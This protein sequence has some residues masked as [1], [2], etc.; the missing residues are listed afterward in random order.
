MNSKIWVM[1]SDG[2][3]CKVGKVMAIRSFWDQGPT[4]YESQLFSIIGGYPLD[5][6]FYWYRN[7]NGAIFIP[8]IQLSDGDYIEFPATS[9]GL[10]VPDT[11]PLS[12][13]DLY[14]GIQVDRNSVLSSQSAKLTSMLLDGKKCVMLTN[15][16][17]G[18]GINN[19]VRGGAYQTFTFM[20][21]Y[22]SGWVRLFALRAGSCSTAWGGWSI[23]G[24]I[25]A[26]GKLW[27]GMK[28]GSPDFDLWISTT[29]GSIPKD[30]WTHITFSMDDDFKGITLL[31]DGI[32]I[33]RKRVESMN[34][35]DYKNMM[36]NQVTIGHYAW[37]CNGPSAPPVLP[38]E[39][40]PL[41]TT[42]D[43][44]KYLGCWNEA[45]GRALP[46]LL[47]KVS[48]IVECGDLAKKASL[49]RFGLQ[50]E[51]ECWGGNNLDWNRG[52]RVNDCPPLGRANSNQVYE[53]SRTPPL[54]DCP[55]SIDGS[56]NICL[57]WVHWFDY[58]LDPNAALSDKGLGF[59]DTKVY[60]EDHTTGWQNIFLKKKGKL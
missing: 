36:Y 30:K 39:P 4:A 29:P 8:K 46:N 41:A 32:M 20:T 13:W 54:S 28:R 17:A 45:N 2:V 49:A 31:L 42:M 51:G 26:E 12:R 9:L 33:G 60:G 11:F 58:T 38:Q 23:E 10:K 35:N 15:S 21:Y 56:I 6:E 34:G 1:T 14:M 43:Q 22:R 40:P 7:V 25:S 50:F 24:G 16:G 53:F 3:A 47:G 57:A 52:G 18:I 19:S 5:L 55:P 27:F 59:T 37:E 48:K 44:L